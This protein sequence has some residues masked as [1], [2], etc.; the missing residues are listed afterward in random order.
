MTVESGDTCLNKSANTLRHCV[1]MVYGIQLHLHHSQEQRVLT[2]YGVSALHTIHTCAS[3]GSVAVRDNDDVARHR[4]VHIIA[5]VHVS[6][7][8]YDS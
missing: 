2:R 5:V 1:S 4:C 7:Q 3:E 6:Q 8:Q